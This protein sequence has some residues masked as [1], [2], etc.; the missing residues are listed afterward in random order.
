MASSRTP[1][2]AG[3]GRPKGSQNK[4]TA[5]ARAAFSQFIDANAPKA[6]ELWER[7]AKDDPA[8]A[9]ELLAKLAEFVM[10][11]LARTETKHEGEVTLVPRLTIIKSPDAVAK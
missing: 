6:Q 7:V 8:R 5:D 2:N 1:P 9:L 11:K 10:P 3:K 4:A